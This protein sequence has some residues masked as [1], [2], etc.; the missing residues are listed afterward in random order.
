M[1]ND[2][3]PKSSTYSR[4]SVTYLDHDH[5]ERKNVRFLARRPRAQ[6]LWRS[7]SRGVALLKRGALDGFQVL[8]YRSEAKIRDACVTRVVHKDIRL[9][10]CQHGGETR[11]R[12]VTYSHEVPMDY[13]ARVE[14]AEAVSD[15]R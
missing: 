11:F 7:P 12:T 3:G 15:I 10:E 14:V 4:S 2:S 1:R 5:R 9:V 8:S 13:I 6:H